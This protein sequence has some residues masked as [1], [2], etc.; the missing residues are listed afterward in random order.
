MWCISEK[1][2]RKDIGK[3]I[4]RAALFAVDQLPPYI[5]ECSIIFVPE[6]GHLIAIK[7]WEED[8]NPDDLKDLDFKFMVK[9]PLIKSIPKIKYINN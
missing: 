7:E 1:L 5:D 2:R 6:M 9:D 8:C 3:H 4:T